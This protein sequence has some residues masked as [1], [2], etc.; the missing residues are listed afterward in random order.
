MPS[1]HG[2]NVALTPHLAKFVDAPRGPAPVSLGDPLAGV[3]AALL[4]PVHLGGCKG[5]V[6]KVRREPLPRPTA[7]DGPVVSG[8]ARLV[9][10][11]LRCGPG[12]GG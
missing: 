12:G 6:P 8:Y 5:E 1:A 7:T 10:L 4:V 9:C 3:P 11:I 2:R